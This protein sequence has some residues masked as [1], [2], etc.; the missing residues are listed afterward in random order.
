MN[1]TDLETTNCPGSLICGALKLVSSEGLTPATLIFQMTMSAIPSSLEDNFASVLA[2]DNLFY[3]SG[4]DHCY[5]HEA[6]VIS[7]APIDPVERVYNS[8]LTLQPSTSVPIHENA[9]HIP[10][11]PNSNPFLA[12]SGTSELPPV[13]YPDP[14][15]MEIE[16][17]E[18][19]NEEADKI[20]EKI[21]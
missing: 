1:L 16:R 3:H 15:L 21:V 4:V 9:T 5:T 17:I 13:A 7:Q 11:V 18:K 20:H 14:L 6:E 8:P 2:Q 10:Q 19:M 12:H